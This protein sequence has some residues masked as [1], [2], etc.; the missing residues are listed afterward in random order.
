M[1]DNEKKKL[2]VVG[3]KPTRLQIRAKV[4]L[5][6]LEWLG[7]PAPCISIACFRCLRPQM[8]RGSTEYLSMSPKYMIG[9]PSKTHQ[10][11]SYDVEH[12]VVI[13]SYLLARL[14]AMSSFFPSYWRD[15]T[16]K[17]QLHG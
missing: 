16:T 13:S 1:S 8:P 9:S 5:L 3:R 4:A 2:E 11:L 15:S 14:D 12:D 17:L 10:R 7:Q 6:S